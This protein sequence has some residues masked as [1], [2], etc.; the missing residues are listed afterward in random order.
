MHTNGTMTIKVVPI[1]DAPVTFFSV[2]G[3]NLATGNQTIIVKSE[4]NYVS[5]AY[6]EFKAVIGAYDIDRDDSHHVVLLKRPTHGSVTFTELNVATTSTQTPKCL[7]QPSIE[8]KQSDAEIPCN[9]ELT[10]DKDRYSWFFKQLTYKP[11]YGF[12]GN[13]SFR[14]IVRDSEGTPAFPRALTVIVAVL[15]N[16]CQNNAVCAGNCDSLLRTRGFDKF[17]FSC[18]CAAGYEGKYCET[19]TND[20]LPNP[21]Q[22]PFVCID[23]IN[24]YRCQ[25]PKQ[26]KVC[27][28]MFPRWQMALITSA[29]GLL[30]AG[31]TVVIILLAKR[32]M[33]SMS[34]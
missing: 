9:L 4:Q 5:S 20:C 21:C 12:Y 17:G 3:V 29:V 16:P 7:P 6:S 32:R 14:V 31:I 24:S 10:Y 13:D 2:N 1:N 11:N 26:Y 15:K 25:C 19:N 28:S 33:E 22:A 34:N 27:K 18:R 23:E 30:V 8:I